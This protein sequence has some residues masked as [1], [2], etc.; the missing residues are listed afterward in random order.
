MGLSEI[1]SRIQN[2]LYLVNAVG[3]PW[4]TSILIISVGE[5]EISVE[6]RRRE[7]LMGG[8]GGG[9]WII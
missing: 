6:I 9:I 4:S 5:L 3:F 7:F 1:T 8:G 2:K